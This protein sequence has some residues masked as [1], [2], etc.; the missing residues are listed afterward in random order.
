MSDSDSRGMRDSEPEAVVRGT[1]GF[2]LVTTPLVVGMLG[3]LM[4]M[5]PVCEAARRT[6]L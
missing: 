5:E 3:L 1:L 6:A 2:W 4:E